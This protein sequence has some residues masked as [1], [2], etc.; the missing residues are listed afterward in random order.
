MNRVETWDLTI[1]YWGDDTH[2]KESDTT[3]TFYH[4]PTREDFLAVCMMTPWTSVWNDT[5]HPII[6]AHDWPIIQTCKKGSHTVLFS[7]GKEVGEL[8]V[9]RNYAYQNASY[10]RPHISWDAIKRSVRHPDKQEWLW[11][12]E[13]AIAELMVRESLDLKA[14]IKRVLKERKADLETYLASVKEKV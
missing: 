7:N 4:P 11:R 5:L 12:N 14:A 1:K 10:N 2:E 8:E 9:W 6:M 13:N 3:F